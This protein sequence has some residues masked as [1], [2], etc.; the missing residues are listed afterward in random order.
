MTTVLSNELIHILIKHAHLWVWGQCV[1]MFSGFR[2]VKGYLSTWYQGGAFRGD[3]RRADN[4]YLCLKWQE[5]LQA[6]ERATNW[7]KERAPSM[8]TLIRVS[9]FHLQRT[10]TH[11]YWHGHANKEKLLKKEYVYLSQLLIFSLWCGTT[12]S[13]F[14]QWEQIYK[15]YLF[16]CWEPLLLYPYV[17]LLFL[18]STL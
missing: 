16:I 2:L 17:Q 12:V 9:S 8:L 5:G 3:F 4:T 13:F 1:R 10:I 6:R 14:W 15:H 11:T 7:E 18:G